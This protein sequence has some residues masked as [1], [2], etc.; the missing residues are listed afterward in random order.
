M[1]KRELFRG[2]VKERGCGHRCE[3]YFSPCLVRDPASG[4]FMTSEII[5][6]HIHIVIYFSQGSEDIPGF[7][8]L[9]VRVL[10]LDAV[11]VP[12]GCVQLSALGAKGETV[13]IRY[14]TPLCDRRFHAAS[15]RGLFL[16]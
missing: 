9:E 6:A 4:N 15:G 10:S 14:C 1:A 5:S 3:V 12:E 7:V 16:G 11:W 2:G 13:R 8:Q